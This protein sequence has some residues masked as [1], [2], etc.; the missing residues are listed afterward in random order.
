MAV[1]SACSIHYNYAIITYGAYACGGGRRPGFEARIVQ[2][3]ALHGLARTRLLRIHIVVV[4]CLSSPRQ[5]PFVG[6][7]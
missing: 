7:M 6:M 3:L 1:I 2:H 5:K 4:D